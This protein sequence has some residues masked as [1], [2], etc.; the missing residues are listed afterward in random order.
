MILLDTNI[1]IAALKHDARILSRMVQAAGRLYLPFVVSAELYYGVEKRAR[2]GMRTEAVLTELDA[3][4]DTIDGVLGC[5]PQVIRQYAQIRA[6]L[7][8]AGTPIGAN[9]L[10]I[11]AQALAEDATLVTDNAREFRRVRGLRLENWLR[12]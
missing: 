5:T 11:A 12:R 3:F 10:W 9:D 7:E 4:H 2:L 8:V 1:C 6:S